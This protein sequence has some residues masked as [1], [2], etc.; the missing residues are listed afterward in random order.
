[1]HKFR[2][3]LLRKFYAE[4]FYCYLH[5]VDFGHSKEQAYQIVYEYD[6]ES[7]KKFLPD[8]IVLKLNRK[9]KLKKLKKVYEHSR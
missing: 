3:F 6:M 4:R 7:I 5:L 8:E 9:K 1:M 2:V